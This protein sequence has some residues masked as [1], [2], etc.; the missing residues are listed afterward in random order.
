MSQSR[1]STHKALALTLTFTLR[2]ALPLQAQGGRGGG[3]GG[4][5]QVTAQ[6]VPAPRFEY[7]GPQSAGRIAAATAV[8]GK[9]GV[10]FAGAASGGVWKSSDGGSTWKPTFDTQSSQAI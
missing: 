6:A 10:Y 8:S 5:A 2:V 9:P 1:T 4:A 3:G 7:V